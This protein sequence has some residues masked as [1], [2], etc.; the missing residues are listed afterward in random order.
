MDKLELKAGVPIIIIIR[1]CYSGDKPIETA[2]LM[3]A[4]DQYKLEY[5]T[6]VDP[7]SNESGGGRHTS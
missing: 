2:E 3:L 1:I 6:R 4:A 7:L 5:E